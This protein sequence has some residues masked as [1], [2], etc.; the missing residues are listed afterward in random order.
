M[1]IY[2][3]KLKSETRY[4]PDS[5]IAAATSTE[6]ALSIHPGYYKGRHTPVK[7]DEE[8]ASL[9]AVESS[10][11]PMDHT[12]TTDRNDIEVT[13]LGQ[14]AIEFTGPTIISISYESC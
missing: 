6:Q 13:Y 12:W 2:L 9:W 1:N 11:R 14:A 8:M 5:F 3:V 4:T 7:F 10:D